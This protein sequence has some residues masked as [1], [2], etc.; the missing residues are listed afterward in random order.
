[1]DWDKLKREY[2]TS[3]ISYRKLAA[4]YKIPFN[5]LFHQASEYKWYDERKQF[6][7][8]INAKALKNAE[9]KAIDYKSVLY[10]L[11]Y[12]VACQLSDITDKYD[13]ETLAAKGVK[14]RDIT[15]AIKDLE[16]ALHIKSEAD[17]KEQAARIKKMEKDAAI[18]SEDEE[19]YGVL[20][21]PPIEPIEKAEDTKHE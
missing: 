3:N 17:I 13:I 18:D 9:K 7:D 8:K 21:L 11:A 14:P 15:G 12:K 4:K 6:R 1:M 16:D 10:E 20:I 5:S 19:K 2:V